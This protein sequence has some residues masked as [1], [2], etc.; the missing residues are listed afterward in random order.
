M[1]DLNRTTQA[2][3]VFGGEVALDTLPAGIGVPVFLQGLDLLLAVHGH[4]PEDAWGWLR[5]S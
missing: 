3:D 4:S 1:L 5:I 2:H